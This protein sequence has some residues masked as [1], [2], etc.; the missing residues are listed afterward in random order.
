MKFVMLLSLLLLAS[1]GSHAQTLQIERIDVV[2][3]GL[4]TATT[5]S[6]EAADTATG[7]ASAL[8]EI[9]HA[10][11]TRTV[12]AQ[13]GVRFGF[14]FTVVGAPVGANVQ[15]HF[16]TVYPIPGLRNPATQE[17]KALG[18]Y[19]HSVTIGESSYRGYSLDYDWEVVPGIWTLQ[20]W[21]QDR[22]LAE[23]QFTVVRQ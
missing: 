21:Y 14:R 4:Y 5:T 9:R 17:L 10:A 20:I 13:Q 18:E 19:D 6:Q 8:T 16:V 1:T 11:T 23:Q 3:Y 2:E 7:T 12:P 15:L 22:K